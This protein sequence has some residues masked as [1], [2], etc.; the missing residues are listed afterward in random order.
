MALKCPKCGADVLA[1]NVNVAADMASCANCGEAFRPSE[2][3]PQKGGSEATPDLTP[4]PPERARC[5]ETPDGGVVV[6]LP[7]RGLSGSAVGAFFFA[8][9]WMLITVTVSGAFFYGMVKGEVPWPLVFFFVPFYAVGIG[10]FLWGCWSA[11]G[12]TGIRVG[13]EGAAV[14]RRLFGKSLEREF[15]LDD[16]RGFERRHVYD[17]NNQ[18]VYAVALQGARKRVHFAHQLSK[19]DQKWLVHQLSETLKRL[20]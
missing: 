18:P 15:R 14:I 6:L 17:M 1:D 3:L 16:V 12:S 9:F 2:V 4:P 19:S 13:P 8:A 20:Q 10:M 5:Q 11:W 7:R